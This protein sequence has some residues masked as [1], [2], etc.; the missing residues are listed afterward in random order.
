MA[1]IFIG[2]GGSGITTVTKIKEIYN[3]FEFTR[4]DSKKSKVIFAGIDV[5]KPEQSE[6]QSIDFIP[7]SVPNP[8]EVIDTHWA[9]DS[10]FKKWWHEGH[11]PETTLSP[12]NAAGRH[13]Y[14]GRL[15]FWQNFKPLTKGIE[16]LIAKAESIDPDVT[17][18]KSKHCIYLI[19]SIGG[20]TG[21]GMFIDVGFLIRDLL[22]QH[23]NFQLYS[24]LFHGII[25]ER[26]GYIDSNKVA[27]GALTQLERWMERPDKF[28]MK[29]Y[30]AKLPA[31]TNKFSALFDMVYLIDEKNL[32]GKQFIR[33]GNKSLIELYMEFGSWLLFILSLDDVD[34][35]LQNTIADFAD[36][37]KISPEGERARRFGSAAVSI[38][39]V[40][41][42]EITDWLKGAFVSSFENGFSELNLT[43]PTEMLKRLKIYEQNAS[44]FSKVLRNSDAFSKLVTHIKNIAVDLGKTDNLDVFNDNILSYKLIELAEINEKFSIWKKEIDE[45]LLKKISGFRKH[46]KESMIKEMETSLNFMGI[47]KYLNNLILKL[48]L[49]KAEIFKNYPVRKSSSE[50]SEIM[51]NIINEISELPSNP[52]K[53]IFKKGKF[54]NLI[55]EWLA[56]SGFNNYNNEN[57]YIN[58]YMGEMLNELLANF[59]ETLKDIARTNADL[60]NSLN[61]IYSKLMKD[62]K[63]LEVS[64][65]HDKSNILNVEKLKKNDFPLLIS[66]PVDREDLE[67][68]HKE[69]MEDL[70]LIDSFRNS[71]WSGMNIE[72]RSLSGLSSFY[73]K[74]YEDNAETKGRNKDA[75]ISTAFEYLKEITKYKLDRSFK[76]QINKSFRIDKALKSHFGR[77][78]QE[79]QNSLNLPEEKSRFLTEFVYQVGEETIGE[80][81]NKKLERE[82]WIKLAIKGFLNKLSSSVNPF[83]SMKNQTEYKS[84]YYNDRLNQYNPDNKPA[85][86]AS[87]NLD[88]PL[89]NFNKHEKLK[90][91]EFR[92]FMLSYMYG[93]PLYLLN[94]V[95]GANFVL[96]NDTKESVCAF[97]DERFLDEWKDN[98]EHKSRFEFNDFL[99]IM[100]L[101]F[102]IIHRTQKGKAKSKSFYYGKKNLGTIT[103]AMYKIRD[104]Y[105]DQIKEEV[106]IKLQEDILKPRASTEDIIVKYNTLLAE[107]DKQLI[108]IEPPK[109][110]GN[111]TAH[112]IWKHLKDQVNVKRDS[113]GNI[114][115]YEGSFYRNTKEDIGN[116]LKEHTG[117]ALF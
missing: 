54:K 42:E 115:K 8:R 14:N 74:L 40:P 102:N 70:T 34:N 116:L 69:L 13:R 19:N 65:H 11:Y 100:A 27:L 104:D 43:D 38:I 17:S 59:Y 50:I 25:W 21:A 4:V 93:C 111:M 48:E 101:G 94:C 1:T 91:D 83:W 80:L 92:I 28:E 2:I 18:G 110:S 106:K 46:L 64:Y 73:D 117:L 37:P 23:P 98:I 47:S 33:K 76:E 39:T 95:K 79:F 6:K 30:D 88:L 81:Q 61:E 49:Q 31:K 84:S 51:K 68:V 3:R 97:N 62:Y 60:V 10:V 41:Y 52:L 90:S 85:I 72:N 77:K 7:V 75:I 99:F 114:M 87:P 86:Y 89:E 53:F 113:K 22:T 32:D 20:G 26:S 112:N 15:I 109:S 56:Y 44:E 107:V 58:A 36:L 71:L 66:V 35:D 103:D 105:A 63:E 96:Y 55:D 57:T 5:D 12:G 16:A 82:E 108:P 78:Y 29:Y 9:K 45:I 24:F 67:Q